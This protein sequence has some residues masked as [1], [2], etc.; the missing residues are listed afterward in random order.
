MKNIQY[1]AAEGTEGYHV[2]LAYP[3]N[4]KQST[5]AKAIISE[6]KQSVKVGERR[7]L[8]RGDTKWNVT[9]DEFSVM[10]LGTAV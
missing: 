9:I 5:G 2:S 3:I 6:L 8:E 10:Y 7:N 4:S 1:F